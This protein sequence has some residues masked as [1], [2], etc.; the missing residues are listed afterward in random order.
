MNGRAKR[1]FYLHTVVSVEHGE[2][3]Y[4]AVFFHT[5]NKAVHKI[6]KAMQEQ[7]VDGDIFRIKFL[8]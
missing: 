6:A 5:F 3:G 7:Q 4:P 2:S 8:L 1:R